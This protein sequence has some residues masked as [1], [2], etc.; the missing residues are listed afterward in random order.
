M[1]LSKYLECHITLLNT[2][3]KKRENQRKQDDSNLR[4]RRYSELNDKR[5]G[6]PGP[7][8]NEKPYSF[9]SPEMNLSEMQTTV[10]RTTSYFHGASEQRMDIPPPPQVEPERPYEKF[11]GISNLF[12]LSNN[13]QT[14]SDKKPNVESGDY[15]ST[16]LH[17]G[18][19]K[20]DNSSGKSDLFKK[21]HI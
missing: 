8:N 10:S 1:G 20:K 7:P 16:L 14:T 6:R 19:Q 5:G 15:L 3:R 18:S 9:K 17:G 13:H 11:S 4:K 12:A 21:L 2:E